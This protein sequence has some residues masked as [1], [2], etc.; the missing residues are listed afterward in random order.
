MMKLSEFVSES[1]SKIRETMTL[2]QETKDK[3]TVGIW[4]V[5]GGAGIAVFVGFNLLSWTTPSATL[6]IV[7]EAVLKSQAAIC[8]AQIMKE[9]NNKAKREELQKLSSYDRPEYIAKEGWDKMPGQK[10]AGSGVSQA[11]AEGLQ[12]FLSAK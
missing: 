7:D 10:E 9:P 1:M 12:T 11:C 5:I 2:K 4:G 3:I 8:V 6:K